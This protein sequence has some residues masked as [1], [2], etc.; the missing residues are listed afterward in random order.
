MFVGRNQPDRPGAECHADQR[1]DEGILAADPVSQPAEHKCPQWPDQEPGGEQRDR[2]EQGGDGVA[3]FEELDRQDR[4]QAPENI[5]IIPFD[6]VSAR[7]G[8]DDASEVRWN[9]RR[10]CCSHCGHFG[11]LPESLMQISPACAGLGRIE[12]WGSFHG[13]IA[14]KAPPIRLLALCTVLRECVAAP[15]AGYRPSAT[16]VSVSYAHL[17]L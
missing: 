17:P 11:S 10:C 15:N 13:N 7:R 2:A 6:N 9:A 1:H 16:G 12:P 5:E 3:L 8:G 14:V 4:G